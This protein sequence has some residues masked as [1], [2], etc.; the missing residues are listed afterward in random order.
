[1]CISDL[2]K[3]ELPK[4]EACSLWFLFNVSSICQ[5]IFQKLMLRV[6]L[7]PTNQQTDLQNTDTYF[8]FIKTDN[9]RIKASI[10]F[11][12]VTIYLFL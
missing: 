9:R 12:L 3:N 10:A 5:K 4:I 6:H 1:M 8:S 11:N 2:K 7:D